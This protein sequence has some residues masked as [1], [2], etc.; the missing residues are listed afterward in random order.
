MAQQRFRRRVDSRTDERRHPWGASRPA[1][2][3]RRIQRS[4]STLDISPRRVL[5]SDQRIPESQ[6]PQVVDMY[7]EIEEGLDGRGDRQPI[8][9]RPVEPG[10]VMCDDASPPHL[11]RRPG[12][13]AIVRR[14][15]SSRLR[16]SARLSRVVNGPTRSGGGRS[17]GRFIPPACMPSYDLWRYFAWLGT[18]P[19]IVRLWTSGTRRQC[20]RC[21]CSRATTHIFCS[22]VD[23]CVDPALGS[24][25]VCRCG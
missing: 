19:R 16:P 22:L 1:T 11:Y 18:E 14:R 17:M 8:P 24:T 13:D 25:P 9:T 15:T 5:P 3:S 20:R 7:R 4:D 6:Q 12:V 2:P 10:S 23:R 21:R